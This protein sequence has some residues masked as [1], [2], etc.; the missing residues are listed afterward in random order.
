[1]KCLFNFLK[2]EPAKYHLSYCI[3]S[4]IS[5]GLLLLKNKRPIDFGRQ[6]SFLTGFYRSKGTKFRQFLLYKGLMVLR[7]VL[8]KLQYK[9][10]SIISIVARILCTDDEEKLT[11]FVNHAGE[12]VNNFVVSL[13]ESYGKLFA[14]YNVHSLIYLHEYVM[15]YNTRL[16]KIPSF[17]F[18]NFTQ[19]LYK[20]MYKIPATLSSK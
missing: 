20:S 6:L 13:K 2:K 11:P 16:D 15:L 4:Q 3:I 18:E 10:F 19:I 9:H 12:L 8:S 14:V 5:D 1:M 17:P 7:D